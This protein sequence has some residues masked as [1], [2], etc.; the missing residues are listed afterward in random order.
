MR[1]L[2]ERDLDA[3]RRELERQAEALF[4]PGLQTLAHLQE[5]IREQDERIEAGTRR[6][7]ADHEK[8]YGRLTQQLGR[9]VGQLVERELA[10]HRRELG[11]LDERLGA[12]VGARLR[13]AR[14]D[15]DHLVALIKAHDQRSRGWVLPQDEA[16]ALIEF[17]PGVAAGRRFSLNFRDGRQWVVAESIELE[18]G[19]I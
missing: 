5:G 19:S 2:V 9:E 12:G 14:R 4:A 13:F 16:G 8:A 10:G 15:A 18:E 17:P 11:R 7:L 6:E 3:Y 1:Q